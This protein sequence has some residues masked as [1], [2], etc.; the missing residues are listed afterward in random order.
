MPEYLAKSKQVSKN[1]MSEKNGSRTG[2]LKHTG[3]T[4]AFASHKETL[5]KKARKPVGVNVLFNYTHKRSRQCH[6]H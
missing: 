3:G 2:V 5:D 6:I 1:T 4:K